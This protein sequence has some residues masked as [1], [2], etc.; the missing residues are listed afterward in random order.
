MSSTAEQQLP[1]RDVRPREVILDFVPET[2]KAPFVLR[3]G[4]MI[5]DYLVLVIVPVGMLILG[6]LFG[7]SGS[8]LLNGELNNAGWLIAI[9]LGLSNFLLL[10]MYS[11]QT[12]GKMLVG[13]RIVR[14]DGG[15]VSPGSIAFRQIA[16]GVFFICSASLSF[17]FSVLSNKG[18]ALHDYLAGTV[19][20]FADR[21]ISR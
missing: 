19:V 21:N 1:V 18:R 12:I 10:P 9:L 8:Q 17:L 15:H 16:G 7:D 13:L 20:I 4:A 2:V 5:I 14:L 6:R 11:G 3:C